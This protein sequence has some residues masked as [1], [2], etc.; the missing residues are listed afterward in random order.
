MHMF[1]TIVIIAIHAIYQCDIKFLSNTKLCTL[2]FRQE[3]INL[4]FFDPENNGSFIDLSNIPVPF[5]TNISGITVT[6]VAPANFGA[7][8]LDE[9]GTP[10]LNGSSVPIIPHKQVKVSH[11]ITTVNQHD[12]A[13]LLDN[14]SNVLGLKTNKTKDRHYNEKSST[15][16][17]SITGASNEIVA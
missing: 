4:T 10:T 12:S 7:I 11:N 5:Q 2:F 13:L 3:E 14:L 8:K 16:E 17:A 1:I 9:D 6:G 15:T